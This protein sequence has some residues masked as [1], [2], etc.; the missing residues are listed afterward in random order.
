MSEQCGTAPFVYPGKAT[1][2]LCAVHVAHGGAELSDTEDTWVKLAVLGMFSLPA[3]AEPGTEEVQRPW[4]QM[5][6]EP[7]VAFAVQITE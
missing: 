6:A 1:H 5:S 3:Q 2:S 4:L 7:D